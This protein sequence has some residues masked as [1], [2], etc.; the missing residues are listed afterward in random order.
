[1]SFISNY[2]LRRILGLIQLFG[3]NVIWFG[4][5]VACGV[6]MQKIDILTI[7]QNGEKKE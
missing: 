3:N 6:G 2:I 7:C 4:N 1:M 5:E